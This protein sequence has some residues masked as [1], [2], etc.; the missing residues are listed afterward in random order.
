MKKRIIQ[1]FDAQATGAFAMEREELLTVERPLCGTIIARR[2][3]DGRL[4]NVPDYLMDTALSVNTEGK[5]ADL[6]I[7]R[8]SNGRVHHHLVP[9]HS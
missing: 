8:S 9:R 3:F 7:S 4:N 5:E 6:L 1:C 2:P